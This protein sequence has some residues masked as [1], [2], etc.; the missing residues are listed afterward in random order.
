MPSENEDLKIAN[1][2]KSGTYM[3]PNGTPALLLEI[4]QLGTLYIPVD[5]ERINTLQKELEKL[6]TM[7]ATAGSA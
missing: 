2:T 1:V 5:L 3:L 7:V 6:A 4:E